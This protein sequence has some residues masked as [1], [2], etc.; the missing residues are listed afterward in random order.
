MTP[1]EKFDAAIKSAVNDREALIKFMGNYTDAQASWEPGAGEW[2]IAQGAEHILLTDTFARQGLLKTLSDAKENKVWDNA[3]DNPEKFTIDQLRRREQGAVPSP[4][5]LLPKEGRLL[6]AM[7]PLLLPSRE[8]TGAALAPYRGH[9][10][11]RLIPPSTRYGELNVYDRMHY[12]GIHDALHMEQM[13]R[14]TKAKGFPS[15]E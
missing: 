8:E 2:S 1:E 12:M 6:S 3:P 13:E 7:I 11:E 9:E 14:V 15:R 5:H 4:D 10:L